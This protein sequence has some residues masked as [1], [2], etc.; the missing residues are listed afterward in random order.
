MSTYAELIARLTELPAALEHDQRLEPRQRQQRDRALGLRLQRVRPWRQVCAWLEQVG[1][2]GPEGAKL[3]TMVRAISALAFLCGLALG[4][5]T[6]AVVFAYDGSRPV[7][8]L[9]VLAV[10]VLLQLG[11]LVLLAVMLLPGG[12]FG[13]VRGIQELL[14]VLSPGRWLRTL[15]VHL[16]RG[17]RL[18]PSLQRG[19]VAKWLALYWSQLFA[20]AFNAAAV[21]WALVLIVVSDLAFGWSTT[22][23]FSPQEFTDWLQLLA[24]PWAQLLPDAVPSEE[25]VAATRYFRLDEGSYSI[26]P[27]D[28]SVLGAWWPFLIACLVVYGLLPR[29]IL[30]AVAR[31]RLRCVLTAGLLEHPLVP[32]L[33]DRMNQPYIDTRAEESEARAPLVEGAVPEIDAAALADQQVLAITWADA[34]S[35]QAIAARLRKSLR[36]RTLE[37]FSA[38]GSATLVEDQAVVDGVGRRADAVWVVVLV[39]TWEP[40]MLECLEFLKAVREAGATRLLIAGV[41]LAEEDQRSQ[42]EEA[43]VWRRRLAELGEPLPYW[44]NI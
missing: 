41:S 8:V 9:Y 22:L 3:A 34:V 20:V 43:Q 11:L 33:L 26:P 35:E 16:G 44:Y 13:V 5:A 15:S 32:A 40:P 27:A 21:T 23:Q 14:S 1:A 42:Y 7:N 28:V 4:A 12:R 39:K 30:W 2:A 31:W 25:M 37:T 36:V 10:L 24:A 19:R 29:L 6:A 18:P 17:A 38:G